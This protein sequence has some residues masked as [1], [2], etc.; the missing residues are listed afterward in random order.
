MKESRLLENSLVSFVRHPT[1]PFE[2]PKE[3]ELP[4]LD[5]KQPYPAYGMDQDVTE[6]PYEKTIASIISETNDNDTDVFITEKLWKA[7][8]MKHV[9]VVHGNHHYLKKLKEL[10]FKT[11]DN[12]IDESYDNEKD[13]NVRIEKIVAAVL[14]IRDKNAYQLYEQ[15]EAIRVHNQ[16]WFWNKNAISKVVNDEIL[17]WLKFFDSSQVPSTKS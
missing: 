12:V 6:K 1:D 2:L 7:I 14:D 11:F 17:L 9:F 16:R 8:L 10:G 4:W 3:F 5:A 13:K 15:T